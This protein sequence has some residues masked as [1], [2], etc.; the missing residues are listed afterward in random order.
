MHGNGIRQGVRLV[1]VHDDVTRLRCAAEAQGVPNVDAAR[2][3][4]RGLEPVD[5]IGRHEEKFALLRAHLRSARPLGSCYIIGE[6]SAAERAVSD[7]PERQP[8]CNIHVC[9]MPVS[10]LLHYGC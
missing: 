6:R 10:Q 4:Q 3:H 9:I 5:V 1:E 2:S 8:A 7:A